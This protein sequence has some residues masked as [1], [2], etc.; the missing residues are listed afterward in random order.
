MEEFEKENLNQKVDSD[1]LSPEAESM[2]NNPAENS[3]TESD[4]TENNTVE[5]TTE[6]MDGETASKKKRNMQISRHIIQ[7]ISFL[8]FP[9]LFFTVLGSLGDI[10]ASIVSG[11]FVL[12]QVVGQLVLVGGILLITIFWGRFF[13]GY[14]CAL[15]AAG[16]LIYYLSQKIMPEKW[17]ISDKA[18]KRMKYVKYFILFL[19]VAGVC[20]V[21]L[22]AVS[23]LLSGNGLHPL[24]LGKGK[25]LS[26]AFAKLGILLFLVFVAGSFF[27]ERFFCRY[28]CPLGALFTPLSKLRL[29]RIRR[30]AS[31]CNGSMNC[32]QNCSMGIPVHNKKTVTF[33]ECIDCMNCIA[34]CPEDCVK[35]NSTPVA[36][37]I[38]AALVIAILALISCMFPSFGKSNIH[39]M[40]EKPDYSYD[41]NM[42]KDKSEHDRSKKSD[43]DK[44]GHDRSKNSNGDTSNQTPN[45]NSDS[46]KSNQKPD[47][48]SDSDTSSQDSNQNSDSD[49]SN[50]KP[51]KKF[52]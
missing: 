21:S 19:L 18:D 10:I 17:K 34:D 40:K 9:A 49:K 1:T 13:C 7:A 48:N 11:N 52:R 23:S 32:S 51:N 28:L 6:N 24:F 16:D 46:N 38:A 47:K 14:V 45:K 29:F 50:Q 36:T 41:K 22:P 5:N 8:L 4:T 15:G 43:K 35:S 37:G 31:H 12:S 25:H 26:S 2:E 33:G 42:D 44:F 39:S 3:S 30:N 20:A 27:I